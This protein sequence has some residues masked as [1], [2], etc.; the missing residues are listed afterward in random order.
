VHSPRPHPAGKSKTALR[1]GYFTPGYPAAQKS[2]VPRGNTATTHA[3][4]ALLF[5]DAAR[6]EPAELNHTE[7]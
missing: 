5:E 1:R 3:E 4:Q 7:D 2:P 6:V